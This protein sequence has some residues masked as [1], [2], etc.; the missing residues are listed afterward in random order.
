MK[1]LQPLPQQLNR[2]QSNPQ[3]LPARRQEPRASRSVQSDNPFKDR[4]SASIHAAEK[5]PNKTAVREQSNPI[6][7]A[8]P[9]SVSDK[10][11]D[12]PKA[13]VQALRDLTTTENLKFAT[14]FKKL[15]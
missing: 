2:A 12:G 11:K 6:L 8:F 5:T 9:K 15:V 4:G 3:G 13:T 10:I 1:T 7:N 14:D